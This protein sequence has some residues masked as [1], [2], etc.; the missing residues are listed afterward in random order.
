VIVHHPEFKK[1][2]ALVFERGALVIVGTSSPEQTS[3][4][5]K[6][7]VP[8]LFRSEESETTR[9][10]LASL[11]PEIQRLRDVS[12]KVVTHKRSANNGQLV[13][14]GGAKKQRRR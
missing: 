4:A 12:Q 5:L 11:G 10:I 6:T 3:E 13:P 14:P 7:L 9:S 1:V 2:R 8:S